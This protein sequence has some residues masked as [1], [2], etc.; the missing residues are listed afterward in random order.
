MQKESS[1]VLIVSNCDDELWRTW[2]LFAHYDI[3]DSELRHASRVWVF[4]PDVVR[5]IGNPADIILLH[6][7]SIHGSKANQLKVRYSR[8][9]PVRTTS[10]LEQ[11]QISRDFRARR[12]GISDSFRFFLLHWQFQSQHIQK[13]MKERDGPDHGLEHVQVKD[14][15]HRMST[16]SMFSFSFIS[17][18]SPMLISKQNSNELCLFLTRKHVVAYKCDQHWVILFDFRYSNWTHCRFRGHLWTESMPTTA[19]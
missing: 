1:R 8:F 3:Y 4:Q 10:A 16:N 2:K 14:H 7:F 12:H 9:I 15:S 18:R 5:I 19:A 13:K 11:Q 6:N 17:D